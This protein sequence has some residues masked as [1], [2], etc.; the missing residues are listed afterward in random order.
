MVY[1]GGYRRRKKPF[2]R[3]D[4]CA[5]AKRPASESGPY[6]FGAYDFKHG[7]ERTLKRTLQRGVEGALAV[8]FEVERDVEEAG[9]FKASVD[10][11]GHF[12]SE[13]AGEFVGGDFDASEFVVEAD[14]KLAEAQVAKGGFGAVDKGEA[15]GGDFGAVW[16]ARSEAGGGGAVP[17]GEIGAAGEFANFGFAEADV[18]ERGEDVMLGG[19]FVAGTEVEGVIAIDAVGDG[20][21]ILFGGELVE[22]AEEFVFTEVAAVTGVGAVRGVVHFVGFDE[23]VADRE[24]LEEGGELI[25]VV[26]GVRGRNCG[27]GEGA[28]ADGLVS[29]PGEVSGV[30]A[31]G[32]SDDEGGEFGEIGQKLSLLLITRERRGF[33]E[34]DLDDGA[35]GKSIAQERGGESRTPELGACGYGLPDAEIEE[36]SLRCVARR[37]KL[38]RARESRATPV[39]MTDF[40]LIAGA[41]ASLRSEQA[42]WLDRV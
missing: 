21:K 42:E 39:G 30:G 34:T 32:K 7:D 27:D 10:G 23:L 1:K 41:A 40:D 24:L 17:R 26:R 28:I 37:A 4:S 14:T 15:L 13:G 35:H 16:K 8:A 9:G 3:V 33:V 5:W 18:E 25:A 20:G 12:G 29:G 6:N 2:G 38:R 19:S 31:T 22:D 36:R 11:G